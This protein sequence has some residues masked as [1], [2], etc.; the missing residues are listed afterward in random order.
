MANYYGKTGISLG[1]AHTVMSTH[2][3]L[4]KLVMNSSILSVEHRTELT[5]IRSLTRSAWITSKNRAFINDCYTKYYGQ[6]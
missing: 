3:K 4:I 2:D 6:T 1:N 5:R